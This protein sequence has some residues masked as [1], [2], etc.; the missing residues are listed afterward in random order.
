M[1]LPGT[2]VSGSLLP[3]GWPQGFRPALAARGGSGDACATMCSPAE[4]GVQK[5]ILLMIDILHHP[6]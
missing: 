1:A 2:A 6:I 4:A 3:G 5:R